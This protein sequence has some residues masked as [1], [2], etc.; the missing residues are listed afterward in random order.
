LLYTYY[1]LNGVLAVPQ[2]KHCYYTGERKPSGYKGAQI[3]LRVHREYKKHAGKLYY[4][5]QT[6]REKQTI[7]RP[8][9][10]ILKDL[11]NDML[12]VNIGEK[13]TILC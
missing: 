3:Y 5:L 11:T 4:K 8:V 9:F 2:A 10:F 7:S 6:G 12:S 13:V 1:V